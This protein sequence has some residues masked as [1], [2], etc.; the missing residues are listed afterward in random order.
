LFLEKTGVAYSAETMDTA[1]DQ[2]MPA[3]RGRCSMLRGRIL[4]PQKVIDVG[5][6]AEG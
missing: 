5:D 1:E 2:E 6:L 4:T 3:C